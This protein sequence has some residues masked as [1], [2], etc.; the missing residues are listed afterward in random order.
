MTDT[1]RRL[2]PLFTRLLPLLA[3]ALL[4][5]CAQPARVTQMTVPNILAPVVAAKPE[6]QNSVT[7]SQVSGGKATN[8]MWTSQVDNP[9][10]KEAL[11]RS[12]EFNGVLAPEPSKARYDVMVNMVDLKQP[13]MG[14]DLTVTAQ[15]EYR[16]TDRTGAKEIYSESLVTP[17]TA[18]FSSSL[19]A[20]ER[21]RLANEGAVRESIKRF[22][23]RLGEVW[24]GTA[25]PATPGT[26]T[27]AT[28]AAPAGKPTS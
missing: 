28:S 16:V 4:A 21:L 13:L 2:H 7:V 23:T 12:L 20:V 11:E 24:S 19:I 5:A 25:K 27:P 14:L 17:Y 9:E 18:D 15:V 8:P 10:F 3:L 22:I 26:S 6:L 1:L